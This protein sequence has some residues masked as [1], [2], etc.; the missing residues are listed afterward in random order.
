MFSVNTNTGA[1][2]QVAKDPGNVGVADW[3]VFDATGKLMWLITQD[4]NC[5]HCDIGVSA[6]NVNTATGALTLVPNSFY[7]MQNSFSGAIVSLA[8]TQ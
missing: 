1:L 7:V 3:P 2:S 8:I 6:Y 5:W 4:E